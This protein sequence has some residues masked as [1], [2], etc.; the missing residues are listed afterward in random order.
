MA[1]KLFTRSARYVQPA[2]TLGEEFVDGLYINGRFFNEAIPILG[3]VITVRVKPSKHLRM[4]TL[5]ITTPN[6]SNGQ[7]GLTGL[8]SYSWMPLQDNEIVREH[9]LT[10]N[11]YGIGVNLFSLAASIDIPSDAP[12]VYDVHYD[13][14]VIY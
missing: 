1:T 12:V 13:L 5:L 10:A 3:A 8:F 14:S 4:R 11:F 6:F 2:W 7:T 9:I